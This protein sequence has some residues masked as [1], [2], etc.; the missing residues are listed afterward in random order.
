MSL[1][2]CVFV[3]IPLRFV[4]II[5]EHLHL[6]H[7]PSRCLL[8]LFVCFPGRLVRA[9]RMVVAANPTEYEYIEGSIPI[10]WDGK[11]GLQHRCYV[12]SL[13]WI[14]DNVNKRATQQSTQSVVPIK[15]NNK[16]MAASIGA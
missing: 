5:V 3:C 13:S 2:L 7:A 6:T 9:K 11:S 14:N 15:R 8:F 4:C 10:E 16:F 1:R 12:L